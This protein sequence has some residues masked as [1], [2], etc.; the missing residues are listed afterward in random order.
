MKSAQSGVSERQIS[1]AVWVCDQLGKNVLYTFPAE[2]Q[3]R[4]FVT[5]RVDPVISNSDYLDARVGGYDDKSG[6]KAD[7]TG[8]KQIGNAFLYFRGSQNEKQIISVDAD[9]VVLDERDRFIQRSIPYIDKRLLH[10][11]LKW[12]RYIST[13]T[14]PGKFIHKDYLASD[15]H[16]WNITCDE[17]GTEQAL[18]WWKN[19]VEDRDSKDLCKIICWKC[20]E[21]IDRKKDGR[22]IPEN[23]DSDVRGYHINGLYN[24]YLN[25]REAWVQSQA[26]DIPT[27]TQFYNQTLGLPYEAEGARITI[28]ALDACVRSY[29]IPY[30]KEGKLVTSCTAGADVG[31]VIHLIVSKKEFEGEDKKARY[32]WIGQ[33]N[34]F[35]GPQDSLEWAIK[36][37]NIETMVV[38]I[39]PETRKV[40][41][42]IKMFPGR[43]FGCRYPTRDF[44]GGYIDWKIPDGEVHVDRTISL[45]YYVSEIDTQKVILP[46]NADSIPNFY[47]QLTSS[48]RI[49]D[50]NERTGKTRALWQE[51]G[52]DH[53]LHAANYDRIA[54][55]KAGTSEDYLRYYSGESAPETPENQHSKMLR[56]MQEL[57][58]KSG[59]KL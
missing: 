16:R 25:L 57:V 51:E 19:V 21:P 26:P 28:Q 48:V 18:D 15:Q 50:T 23:P 33:V 7:R 36:K 5:G 49:I 54:R 1:E 52:A 35:F 9:M 6:K 2:G 56:D 43:V 30:H 14:I 13:P 31:S 40:Q 8:M 20:K 41:D 59:T 46:R 39:M 45:D 3:L 47:D 53:Y 38:D 17:C 58:K 44:K 27:I 12:R 4:D 37:Y 24:P 11:N 29:D 55:Q 42:L 22:W 10:S 32:V 34:N